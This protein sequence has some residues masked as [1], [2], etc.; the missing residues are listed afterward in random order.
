[1]SCPSVA[2]ELLTIAGWVT[3][4]GYNP[5]WVRKDL[6]VVRRNQELRGQGELFRRVQGFGRPMDVAFDPEAP[7]VLFVPDLTL[8]C[9]WRVEIVREVVG[10]PPEVQVGSGRLSK[11]FLCHGC[12]ATDMIRSNCHCHG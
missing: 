2:G 1:M 6:N 5:V 12:G 8:H 3:S 11:S 10:G 7:N 4:P 9:I